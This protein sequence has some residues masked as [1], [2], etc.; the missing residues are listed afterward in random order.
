MGGGKGAVSL[1]NEKKDEKNRKKCAEFFD[2]HDISDTS[3]R[4]MEI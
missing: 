4:I 1:E 2:V 3:C